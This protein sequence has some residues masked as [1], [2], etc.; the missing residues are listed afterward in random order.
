VT[1]PIE[2]L[3]AQG[4]SSEAIAA[5][6][7]RGVTALL[8][9]QERALTEHGVLHGRNL[10]ISAPTSSGKT[11]VAE[12]AALRHLERNRRVVYLVPTKA[13]AEEKH[14]EFQAFY[15][16]LGYRVAVAT[17]ERPD[18]D[19]VVLAGRYDL[20]VAVY[21]KWK[22]YLVVRPEVQA[23]VA[24]VVADEVQS[25][26][27]AG[28]GDA[29][30]LLL[31]KVRYAAAS[32]GT[33][34]A[35]GGAP[36][37]A[38][39]AGGAG[40]LGK[41]GGGAAPCQI[42]A[43]SAVLGDDAA[44]LAAWLGCELLTFR[45]R[46][47]EL[48]EGVYDIASGVFRF[49]GSN[50]GDAGEEALVAPRDDASGGDEAPEDEPPD[51]RRQA[52]FDLVADLAQTRG[53]Q[54]IVFVPT[55]P[56][57]RNWARHLASLLELPPAQAVLDELGA[58]EDTHSRELLQEALRH[59]VA[60]HNADLSWD[61]RALIEAHFDTG[62][63][64]V[65]ISTPTLGQG[66]NL[67]GRNVVQVPAMV[68][69]DT[70]TGRSAMAALSRSRFRNQGG[71]GAR[72]RLGEEPFGRSILVARDAHEGERLL[73]DYV[74]GEVEPLEPRI[75]F[76]ALEDYALDLVASRMAD[77]D[78]ALV[79]F[80]HNTFSG[81]TL[82]EVDSAPLA[83]A[84]EGAV[85]AL[86][87]KHLLARG[88]DERL[89]ATGLGEVAAATG[90]R[91]ASV[92]RMAAWLRE[93]PRVV[94][95]EPLEALVVLASTED[96][97][98]FA[99]GDPSRTD[100]AEAWAAPL[101]ERLLERV[102]GVAPTVREILCPDGGFTRGALGDFRKALV[103]D[104]WIGPDET[105]AIEEH[106][107]L[108]SGTVANLAAHFAWLAQAAAALARALALPAAAC[109]ALDTLSG[110]LVLGCAAAGRALRPLH[111]PGLSRAYVQALLREGLGTPQALAEA[112]PE[113]LARVVPPRVATHLAAEAA[114]LAA[115]AR[116]ERAPARKRKAADAGA[117]GTG[118]KVDRQDAVEE[119][120]AE[121]AQAFQPVQGGRSE[122]QRQAGKPAPLTALPLPIA[123]AP[124]PRLE[125]L[126]TAKPPRARLD[127]RP[128]ALDPDALALLALLAESAGETV[129]FEAIAPR[130]WPGKRRAAEAQRI[131]GLARRLADA[132]KDAVN[133]EN[134]DVP[135]GASVR[136][137]ILVRLAPGDGIVLDLSPVQVRRVVLLESK[138]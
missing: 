93:G 29:I 116:G 13:L 5:L 20:L 33:P 105:R 115:L 21:E 34:A 78:A 118:D 90:L 102:E 114:R 130:V 98:D 69:T 79:A 65:L 87:E 109:E 41:P 59:G 97:R 10:V 60:F 64:R 91:P 100:S 56:M 135:S 127:G 111:V 42:L 35:A 49:R 36:G 62:A 57:S 16:P 137:S 81:R 106:F 70:H 136:A 134:A 9:L 80:F 31:T 32:E 22:S 94:A 45:R 101:R 12:L 15:G 86:V 66:V 95:D 39:A 125:L 61:L 74:E 3:A 72:Y 19:G 38:R 28:R 82:W 133:E 123:L 129:P 112:A 6:R 40:A 18:A 37:R 55:R 23:G 110:R 84:V 67:H 30:D 107:Q 131:A 83:R 89:E 26:G 119:V 77:T 63:I 85:A 92:L 46:P 54:V 76:E 44:R 51:Y 17:R 103:L 71:R 52:I 7:A 58:Y 68:V 14:R 8:P 128:L 25:I 104:A 1:I 120:R 132:L 138:P 48:R 113:V 73:R 11:L 53:E 50:G 27:E 75:G 4:F 43:L 122:N 88:F 96:A 126:L 2:Q 121:A 124:P 47:V 24:L 108:F 117:V 99:L